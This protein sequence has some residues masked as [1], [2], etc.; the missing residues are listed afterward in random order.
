NERSWLTRRARVVRNPHEGD[1]ALAL[2]PET[3][4]A[5]QLVPIQPGGIYRL[6]AVV[7]TDAGSEEVQLIASEYGGVK[8]SV[9]SALTQF[10]KV[11][12]E[13][14]SARAADHVLI[15]VAHPAGPGRGYVDEI[16]LTKIGDT[17]PPRIED[18]ALPRSR[19]I[20]EEGGVAQQ[21]DEVMQWFLDAKFGMFIHWGVYAAMDEG[22][23]WVMHD[24][25]YSPKAYRERAENPESG[26]TASSYDPD[27]WAALAKAA[28]MKYVVL[29]ARHHDGYALFDSHHE[30]SWTSVQ[31]LGRDFIREYVE[32]VRRAGLQVGLYYSP[33][34]WRY[35]G[36]YNVTGRDMKPN[37]WNYRPEPW[38]K[39]N[40]RVMKEEAYEQVTRL[41]SDYGPRAYMFWDGAWLGQTID[42]ELEDRF[43]DTGRYQ[44]PDKEWP[45]GESCVVREDGTGKALGIMGL[46]RKF[47]PRMIVN[48]RF[49]WIGDVH[50]EEG[51][52]A[53][54]GPIRDR[55]VME[56]CLPLMKG[57]WGFRPDRPVFSF[58]EVA[59]YLSDC[60]I[61]NINLLLNVSPDRHGRIPD[62]Q[63]GVLLEMG[64]WLGRVGDAFFGTRGGPWQPLFGEYGFTWREDK[65]Y[66]HILPGYEGI[67]SASFTTQ[68][69]GG[70]DVTGV[71]DLSSNQP[72][73]WIENENGTLTV[74]GIGYST[75]P[76]VTILEL[77]LAESL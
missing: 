70:R 7:K 35:P 11:S 17:P 31:H 64:N 3:G 76:P 34:S 12:L 53:S 67:A 1:Y 21:P 9:S 2:G 13:F 69:L 5:A 45:I 15:T 10:T 46:V 56:K 77:T 20:L 65:I 33:M 52:S 6:S 48:E 68:S 47:Q 38:H 18:M 61:R 42:P 75:D 27:E 16:V 40:A 24:K 22:A 32:A 74:S 58:E 19:H 30:N 57:G 59:V 62:N 23:E 63:R 51:V 41:L 28:G 60:A 8:A 71:R 43:W 44:N 72:L 4:R 25:A 54:S 55:Q 29:T 14:E 37:V 50:A 66:C 36:Y 26:F 49:S 73:D 39:E